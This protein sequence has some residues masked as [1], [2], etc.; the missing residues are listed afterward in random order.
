ML[1]PACRSRAAAARIASTASPSETP[2]ARLKRDGRRR[3][4]ADVV[5]LRAARCARSTRGDR[6]QRHLLAAG[7][8][9][10]VEAGRATR[11]SGAI[12]GCDFE[13][14]AVLVGLGEDRR[15]DALAEGAVERVV[16]RG[17]GDAEARGGVA[18]DARR[19]PPGPWPA[20]SLATSRSSRQRA[21]AARSG[22]APSRRARRRWRS[23]SDELVLRAARPRRRW[24]GPAPAAGRARCP[25]PTPRSRCRRRMIS[26]A[27]G[28][29][30]L[31][32]FR[33][34]SMRPRV[35]RRVGA[36]DAD[37]RATG[38]RR[39]DPPGSPRP[40]PA[41]ARPCASNETTAAPR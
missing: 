5:D 1:T 14:H 35:Q 13:D 37:E 39:R 28:S 12:A 17:G 4:L 10:Q 20:A 3:E 31:R 33:L 18:V 25:A 6:R 9:A 16:D 2:G 24:S 34:I 8:G 41:G 22:A 30:S 7:A 29:R 15:D 38:S 27:V 23:R 40:A 32:G 26:L 21:A 36:V 11:A 19:T